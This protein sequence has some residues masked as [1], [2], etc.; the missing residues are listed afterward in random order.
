M[1]KRV[2]F[3]YDDRLAALVSRDVSSIA[4]VVEVLQK[5]DGVLDGT[6]DGLK[7]FNS[8]YLEV[9]LAVRERVVSGA[10]DSPQGTTFIAALDAVFASFYFTALRNWFACV[11]APAS[12]RVLFAERSNRSLARIQ[13]ALAG[14][15][16]H[17]NRDLAPAIARTC[18]Q[19]NLTPAHATAEYRAYTVL[20]DT[21]D[22]LINQAKRDLMVRLPGD[23]LPHAAEVEMAVGAWGIR[24]SRESA[25]IHAEVLYQV[26]GEPLLTERLMGALD[27]AAALAGNA[28]L[29][30]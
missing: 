15:N 6:E 3:P 21:L 11:S 17:I 8:L 20:N 9:T 16:A 14:V 26:G 12:W 10:F 27:H 24:A 7:W 25:W 18:K 19:G 23:L 5:L 13:F 29:I 2:Q 4:D 28:L 1:P 30:L 22:D